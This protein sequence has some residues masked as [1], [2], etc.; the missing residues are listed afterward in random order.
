MEV[1]EKWD[2][3]DFEAGWGIFGAL[4][5]PGRENRVSTAL[6]G[7]ETRSRVTVMRISN[8]DAKIGCFLRRAR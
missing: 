8:C 5:I 6:K 2:F 4:R 1:A 7:A 3:R